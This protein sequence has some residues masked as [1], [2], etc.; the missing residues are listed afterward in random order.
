MD[1]GQLIEEQN[2]WLK[3]EIVNGKTDNNYLMKAR[4]KTQ[5][6]LS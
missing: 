3:A 6:T 5:S 2:E 4:R 1:Y